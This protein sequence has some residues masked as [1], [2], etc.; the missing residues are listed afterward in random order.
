M[1]RTSISA[2]SPTSVAESD[3]V[4]S[5]E[6]MTS[7]TKTR[8]AH[9]R[10]FETDDGTRL[11]YRYW[12]AVN[13]PIGP[14]IILLHRGHEHSGRLQHFV[15]EINL[16]GFAMFAWD[17]RGHGRSASDTGNSPSFGTF[18]KDVDA[19][20]RHVS[21]TYGIPFESIAIVSQSVGSVL[22]AAWAHDYAPGIRCMVLSAPA[23][24][25]K[26]YAPFAHRALKLLYRLRGDF[27]INSYVKPHILTHDPERI[28]SYK[29][30][31]LITRPISVRVLLGLDRTSAR[32]VADAQAILVPTQL[33]I[34]GRD[35]VVHKK[36]QGEFFERMGSTVK[37]LHVFDR[38]Y[39]DILGEKDRR[40]ALGKVRTFILTMFSGPC[41]RPRLLDADKSGYTKSEFDTLSR[42]LPLLSRKR[43]GFALIKLGMRVGSFFSSGIRLGFKTGF[44]SGSTLDYVYLNRASGATP[45]RRWVDRSYIN[46]I[47]WKGIRQRKENLVQA[48]LDS[49]MRLCARGMPVRVLDIAAGHGRYVLEALEQG[50]ARVQNV[51]LRDLSETNVQRGLALIQEKKLEHTVRFETG[52]AFNRESLASLRPRPTL[53]VVSG[54]YELFPNNQPVL[55]SLAGLA[56]AIEPGGFLVYT[57]QPFHPQL[58]MI[59][60]TLPSHREFRP[61]TMRR[62]TQAEIDQLVEASGF[63]KISQ[64]IDDWGIFSVSIAQK[65]S[66]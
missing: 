33:L 11:F 21:S 10:Y 5:A 20:A 34:S 40:L 52:D 57:G 44:D 17:A 59:A 61:W 18:V 39:H 8:A 13:A 47:G 50:A 23:F 63:R 2:F 3:P 48:L 32:I 43:L 7:S 4:L 9:E 64:R 58:E 54:L 66:A 29:A 45:I 19:F 15:D 24:K 65:A 14:A 22:A 46:A 12:P 31:P 51:L 60:R 41:Q 36:P 62:R 56:D 37:E 26:L 1:H 28:A 16:P 49:M 35:W 53:A 55:E 38:F 6:P 30:D 25:I 27:H 42:P